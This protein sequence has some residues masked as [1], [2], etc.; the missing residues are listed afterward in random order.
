MGEDAVDMGNGN[1]GDEELG[2]DGDGDGDVVNQSDMITPPER[3][4]IG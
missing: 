4:M 2:G 3:K 1:K